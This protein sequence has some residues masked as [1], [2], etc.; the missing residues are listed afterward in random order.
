[1]ATI[2]RALNKLIPGL[3]RTPAFETCLNSSQQKSA[4]FED[5]SS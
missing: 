1:M 2:K 5:P 3:T 4:D